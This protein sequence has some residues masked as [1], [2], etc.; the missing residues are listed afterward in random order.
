[1]GGGGGCTLNQTSIV[2][3]LG[4]V[5]I[6][7]GVDIVLKDVLQDTL[8]D[9]YKIISLIFTLSLFQQWCTF[10]VFDGP[11]VKW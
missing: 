9:F 2:V 10:D 8:H 5:E 1:M 6:V 7:V 4:W 3:K 11:V